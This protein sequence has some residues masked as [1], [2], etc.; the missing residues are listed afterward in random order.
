MVSLVNIHE[1]P[2]RP[3]V[4]DERPVLGY[5]GH[6]PHGYCTFTGLAKPWPIVQSHAA[7]LGGAVL[8]VAVVAMIAKYHGGQIIVLPTPYTWMVV[9]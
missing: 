9:Q 7:R 6:S 2:A 1:Q 8:V 5:V 4:V 3:G